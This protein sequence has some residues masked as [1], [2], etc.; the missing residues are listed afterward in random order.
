MDDHIGPGE[1]EPK[2]YVLEVQS[3]VIRGKS[4]VAAEEAE[5]K[6]DGESSS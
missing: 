1:E 4:E 3:V 6:N 2:H 5:E